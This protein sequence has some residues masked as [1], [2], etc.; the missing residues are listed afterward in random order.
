MNAVPTSAPDP[1]NPQWGQVHSSHAHSG[2]SRAH[3]HGPEAGTGRRV[4][5]PVAETMKRLD[6]GLKEGTLRE[7][8]DRKDKG[9]EEKK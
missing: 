4:D 1:R 5:A 7:R 3:A 8:S 6:K 2:D 9:G